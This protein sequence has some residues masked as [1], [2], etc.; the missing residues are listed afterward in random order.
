MIPEILLLVKQI[1]PRASQIDDLRTTIPIFFQPRA[2][3]AVKRVRDPLEAKTSAHVLRKDSRL[4]MGMSLPR[5]HK[6]RTCSDN[7]RKSI[8]HRY[9]RGWLDAH[10]CRRRGICRRIYHKDDR[11]LCRVVY[12]T[13]LDRW[14]LLDLKFVK[15]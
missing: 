14:A 12:G 3:K 15:E 11:L 5:H 13:L 4:G 2:L 1:G 9:A 10:S 8:H 7:S 6:P